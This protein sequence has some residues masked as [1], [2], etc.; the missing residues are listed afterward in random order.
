MG[1]GPNGDLDRTEYVFDS[2]TGL[3]ST[4]RYYSGASY[5]EARY[6]YDGAARLVRLNDWMDNGTDGLQYAYDPD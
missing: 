3:L 2:A 1:A 6:E 4:V 5:Q